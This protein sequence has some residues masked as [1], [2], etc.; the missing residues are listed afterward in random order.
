[1]VG[2]LL[3]LA[4]L[5]GLV[6]VF[7]GAAA[8]AIFLTQFTPAGLPYLFMASAIAMV[9][10]GYLFEK[11]QARLSLATFLVVILGAMA[12]ATSVIRVLLLQADARWAAVVLG[13]WNEVVFIVGGLAFWALAE[14]VLDVRQAKRLFGFV[15]AG[16]AAAMVVGGACLPVIVGAI[17]AANLLILA[18]A[19]AA[20]SV[21][22]VWGLARVLPGP[23]GAAPEARHTEAS[24]GRATGPGEGWRDRYFLLILGVA[25]L[26][27][28][29]IFILDAAYFFEADAHFAD[30]DQ[31]AGFLGLVESAVAVA[32]LLGRAVLTGRWLGRYGVTVALLT[33]PLATAAASLL[34]AGSGTLLGSSMLLFAL[35]V[36]AKISLW[37]LHEAVDQP[38]FLILYQPLSPRYRLWAQTWVD[39]VGEPMALGLTGLGLALYDAA[40]GMD[41]VRLS[42]VL[43]V[44]AVVWIGV[45]LAAGR[46]YLT[47]LS[48]ALARRAFGKGAPLVK[49]R[50]ALRAVTAR[51]QSPHAGEVLYCLSVLEELAPDELPGALARLLA[52]PAYQVRLEALGRIEREQSVAVAAAVFQRVT[53]DPSAAVRAAA[54]RAY[55]ALRPQDTASVAAYLDDFDPEVRTA[56]LI[57]LLRGREVDELPAVG[58]RLRCLI[59]SPAAGER[60]R[61]AHVIGA[62]ATVCLHRELATLLRDDAPEVRRAALAAAGTARLPDLWPLLVQ[63]LTVP[64]VRN[65]AGRALVA[66]GE[67]ALPALDAAFHQEDQTAEARVRIVRIGGRIGGEGAIALLRRCLGCPDARVRH[68]SLAAL[69]ACGYRAAVA[70]VPLVESMIGHEA[71]AA[72]WTLGALRAVGDEPATG[73]LR[74]ALR[75]ELERQRARVLVLLGFLYPGEAMRR[76]EAGI[77]S[78]ASQQRAYAVELL[79][80]LLSR[81]LKARVMPLVD[82]AMLEHQRARLEAPGPTAPVGLREWLLQ[83]HARS[84]EDSSPWTRACAAY[85]LGT[86]P[87]GESGMLLTI[88]KVIMLRA[89]SMF[90]DTPDDVLADVAAILVE[91]E[92]EAGASIIEEGELGRTL[93]IV[94]EG[95]VRVHRGARTLA[96]LGDRDVFGELAALDPERRSASVTAV[97]DTRLLCLDHEPLSELMAERIEVAQGIIRFLCQRYRAGSPNPD[98]GAD[99][100]QASASPHARTAQP[101]A[102]G[103]PG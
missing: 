24:H 100:R 48:G 38:A 42:H 45:S 96:L 29:G 57:G 33:L 97:R 14:R 30:E 50:S 77:G 21:P 81:E 8:M 86:H 99:P 25:V 66:A 72:S 98:A 16:E 3:L 19:A 40:V 67:G 11:L 53:A 51:L 78:S 13:S 89:V 76:V 85:L 9:F 39:T 37:F 49:D 65:A 31:L 5:T 6:R 71:A 26:N 54:L 20:L 62:A 94:V 87:N 80:N 92:L 22:V 63:S 88:E 101:V 52:H 56:A 41:A 64:A 102:G 27:T 46:A 28:V 15:G 83:I 60:E 58:E 7:L 79:D 68:E 75:T 91:R 18:A 74:Q 1:M 90:A 12:A 93:Y 47:A 69:Q 61:A 17:G 34:I 82:D 32:I 10:A 35:V 103:A 55:S 84:L 59:H 73:L 44:V 23:L 43:L 70:D 4:G 95:Q 36:L 2:L